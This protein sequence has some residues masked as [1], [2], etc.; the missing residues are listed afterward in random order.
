[1]PVDLMP[2]NGYIEV[3]KKELV[4]VNATGADAPTGTEI[5]D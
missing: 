2:V 3:I 1:M 4:A 5:I